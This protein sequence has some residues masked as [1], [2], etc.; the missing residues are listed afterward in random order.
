VP[1]M[2]THK[3]VCGRCRG[4]GVLHGYPGVYTQD[5]FYEDPDFF[6]DYREYTRTCEDCGGLRV[7]DEPDLERASE[8]TKQHWAEWTQ[9][10]WDM[11]RTYEMERRMGA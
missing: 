7:L 8:A 1:A 4:E 3:I 10:M 9:D 2:P 11:H 6:D 5:D